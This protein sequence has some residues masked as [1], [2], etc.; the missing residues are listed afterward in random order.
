MLGKGAVVRPPGKRY[1]KGFHFIPMSIGNYVSI[2]EH[3]VVEAAEIGSYVMIGKNCVISPLCMIRDCCEI[4]DGSVLAPGTVV[5]PFSK[6][7]GVPAKFI[8]ELP[9]CASDMIKDY[10]VEKYKNFQPR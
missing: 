9:G 2:G 6:Y 1:T 5:P 7:G 4:V 8:C 10:L 3:S